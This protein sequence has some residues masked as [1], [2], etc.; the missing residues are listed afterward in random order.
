MHNFVNNKYLPLF[1]MVAV[2]AVFVLAPQLAFAQDAKSLITQKGRDTFNL[3]YAIVYS[4]L[5]IGLLGAFAAAS[6]GR[7]DWSHVGKIIIG[8]VGAGAV[9]AIVQ[10]FAP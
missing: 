4:I 8:I 7:L 1:L 3:A 10:Y 2:A 9:V 5:G 6:F